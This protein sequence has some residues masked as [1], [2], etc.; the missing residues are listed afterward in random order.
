MLAGPHLFAAWLALAPAEANSLDVTSDGLDPAAVELGLRARVGDAVDTCSIE[1]TRTGETEYRVVLRRPKA[2][3]DRRTLIL[4]GATDEDRSRELA[5]TLAVILDEA[6]GTPSDPSD[7]G[8]PADPSKP[9][10][11]APGPLALGFVA[12]DGQLALGPPRHL[13]PSLGLGLTGGAWLLGDHLQPRARVAWQHGW[14]GPLEVHQVQVGVGLAAGVPI[15]QFW[16]GGL[17]LPTAEW[18]LARQVRSSST[19]RGGGE[20][21]VL[22][23]YRRRHLVAGVRTGVDLGFPAA[24]VP[25]TREVVRW[26]HVRW[27]L[28]IEL[29]FGF[30]R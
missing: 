20:L 6:G 27:L 12:I 4:V 5:A 18:T 9:G 16:V 23:Q 2:R 10:V 24:R 11:P 17:M 22:A 19:W 7:P 29:G 25:G 1:V 8:D 28:A 30:G 14:T 13:D 21:S 26:G 15:R 3:A